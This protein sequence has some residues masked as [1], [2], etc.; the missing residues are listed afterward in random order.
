MN[1]STGVFDTVG[2]V[3]MRAWMVMSCAVSNVSKTI[4]VDDSWSVPR[5]NSAE[6]R[7]IYPIN[8]QSIDSP[9]NL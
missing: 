8:A 5:T 3:A 1:V 7:V 6:C 9:Y 2:G 4:G